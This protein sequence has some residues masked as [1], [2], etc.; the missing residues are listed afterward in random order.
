MLP[1]PV[2]LPL[3]FLIGLISLAIFGGG[4]YLIAAWLL[5][6]ITGTIYLA[7]GVTMVLWT[8]VGRWLVLLT[9]Q[10]GD[11]EPT[12]DRAPE[13][14]RITRSDGRELHVEVYGPENG[15][16]L[17]LTHGWGTNS[18]E[19]YYL[20]TRLGRRFR[21]IAW[22]LPGLGE[23]KGPNNSD[24][25]LDGMAHDLAAVIADTAQRPAILVGHSIGG[26]VQLSLC[27]LVPQ[28]LGNSVAGLVFANTTYTNPVRTATLSRF[29]RAIQ[30]PVL[31]PVLHLIICLSPTCM[32]HELAVVP[33]RICS[34]HLDAERLCRQGMRG[35]LDST[36]RYTP[37]ASPAVEARGALAMLR[38]DE[39]STLSSI[40]VPALTVVGERTA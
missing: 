30:K 17:L 4:V 18:T 8:V 15:R 38:F 22:D 19:W 35:Q 16:P 27:R 28:A 34:P 12:S 5:G 40:H 10:A 6:V 11:D 3:G 39:T 33:E 32:A 31:E 20:K 21:L 37:Q 36:T 2:T 25:S 13:A 9:P 1:S 24:Y 29:L 7:A 14:R 26:M 23:S